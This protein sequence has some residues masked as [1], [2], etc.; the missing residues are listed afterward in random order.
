[1][2]GDNFV[3]LWDKILTSSIWMEPAPTRLVFI[4]M[5]LLKNKDGIVRTKSVKALAHVAR[6]TEKECQEALAKFEAP[7]PETAGETDDGRRIEKVEGGWQIL[8][9]EMYRYSSEARRAL[10]RA[11]KAKQ[12]EVTKTKAV[13]Q[14]ETAAE[15]VRRAGRSSLKKDQAALAAAEAE[16]ARRDQELVA[17]LKSTT[18]LMSPGQ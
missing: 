14:T 2:S 13:E 7:E 3:L 9:H 6:V 16:Q 4:T 10:W 17:Q 12:R 18:G 15:K 5:L 11:Q 1:M 8:N